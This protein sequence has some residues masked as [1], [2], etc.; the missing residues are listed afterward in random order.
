MILFRR[1][2]HVFNPGNYAI[3]DIPV[4]LFDVGA[5]KVK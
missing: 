4:V 1:P 5:I 3:D 2:G